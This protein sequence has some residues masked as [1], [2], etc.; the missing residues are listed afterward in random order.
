MSRQLDTEKLQQLDS[1]IIS[2]ENGKLKDTI[3]LKEELIDRL[4]K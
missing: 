4:Y 3:L 2:S 1:A